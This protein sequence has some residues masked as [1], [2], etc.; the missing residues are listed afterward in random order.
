MI[1]QSRRDDFSRDVNLREFVNLMH[2]NYGKIG[3]T[4]SLL[5]ILSKERQR[6]AVFLLRKHRILRPR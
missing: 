2:Y 6:T 3:P 5:R 1:F 4:R